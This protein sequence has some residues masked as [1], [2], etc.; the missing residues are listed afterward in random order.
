MPNHVTTK[1]TVRGDNKL[2]QAFIDQHITGA[3][4]KKQFDFNTIIPMPEV[5]RDSDG[6]SNAYE[7]TGFKNWY[8]WSCANW[9]TKWNSYS[10]SYNDL[11][12][13][14]RVFVMKFET[15]WSYP[16]RVMKKL[17]EMHPDLKFSV[18]FFDEGW[19]FAGH[20]DA[21]CPDFVDANAVY[22]EAVYGEPPVFDEYE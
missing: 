1:L 5:L 14:E 13:E 4:G 22:Y 17:D 16:L 6:S 20:G 12:P 3:E 9:G 8:D 15:A 10:L 19:N 18:I 11:K 21:A 7:E 2:I